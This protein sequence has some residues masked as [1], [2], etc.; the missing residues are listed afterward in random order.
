MRPEAHW[1][2]TSAKVT[3][4]GRTIERLK[5]DTAVIFI[6][7]HNLFCRSYFTRNLKDHAKFTKVE[8]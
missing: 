7:C 1:C 3:A 6:Y 5:T 8:L 2:S 4:M